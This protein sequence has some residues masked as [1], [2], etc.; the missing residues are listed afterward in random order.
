MKVKYSLLSLLEKKLAFVCYYKHVYFT[1]S[2]VLAEALPR[3]EATY[4]PP[5]PVLPNELMSDTME[6]G[7]ELDS[8]DAVEVVKY[9]A[10]DSK[11]FSN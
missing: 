1:D 7:A 5:L 11:E 6:S 3:R 10:P 8:S 4:A 2:P 9:S